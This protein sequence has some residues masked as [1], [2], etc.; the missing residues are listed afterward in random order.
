MAVNGATGQPFAGLSIA[1]GSSGKAIALWLAGQVGFQN[2]MHSVFTPG[3]GWGPPLP[4]DVLAGAANEQSVVFGMND[5]ALAGWQQPQGT[6]GAPAS[7]WGSVFESASGWGEPQVFETDENDPIQEPSVFYDSATN[8]FGAVWIQ[9]GTNLPS[10]Y[11]SRL[12]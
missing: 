2:V 11:E 1:I 7:G 6:A 12:Q 5:Q 4:I 9:S 8:T 3:T 10:V